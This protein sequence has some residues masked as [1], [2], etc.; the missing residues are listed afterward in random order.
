MLAGIMRYLF[1]PVSALCL[2]LSGCIGESTHSYTT[3]IAG[4][5]EVRIPLGDRSGPLP[6]SQGDISIVVARFTFDP[7]EKVVFHMFAFTDKSGRLPR[8][9]KVEDVTESEPVVLVDDAQPKL[10]KNLWHG[11][12]EKMGAGDPRLKWVMTVDNA[13]MIYRFT[14]VTAD[15]KTVVIHQGAPCPAVAKFAIRH[16]FGENY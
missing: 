10:E 5:E 12:S 2:L 6:V 8:H 9:V 11:V 14:I 1:L 3:T 7:A 15:G 4:G 13:I 16:A